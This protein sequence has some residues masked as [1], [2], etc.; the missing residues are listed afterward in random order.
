MYVG[1]VLTYLGEAGM[2]KQVWPVM[3]LPLVMAYVNWIVIPV[4]EA[5]LTEVFGDEYALYRASVRRWV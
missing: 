4:E 1:L 2:L 5:K 3:L